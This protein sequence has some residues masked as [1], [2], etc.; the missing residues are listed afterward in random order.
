MANNGGLK[1]AI[2]RSAL[3]R[4]AAAFAAVALVAA[5]CRTTAPSAAIDPARVGVCSWS[6]REPLSG[7]AVQME[8]SGVKGIHLALGPFIAPDERHGA[9]EPPSARMS[10]LLPS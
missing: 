1:M 7:V 8:K 6:W 9:A 4:R 2:S 10:S 3:F 5:G